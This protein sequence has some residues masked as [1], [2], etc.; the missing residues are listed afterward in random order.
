MRHSSLRHPVAVVRKIIAL[1]QPEFS[2]LAGIAESTLAKIESL[3]LPLSKQNAIR[4][5]DETG[6]S[7]RWLL[8]GNPQDP[9]PA[10]ELRFTRDGKSP[11]FDQSVFEKLRGQIE[12]GTSSNI[13]IV[14]YSSDLELKA[15]SVTA[16]RRDRQYMFNHKLRA[17]VDDLAK[18]FP[19][20]PGEMKRQER[21]IFARADLRSALAESRAAVIEMMHRHADEKIGNLFRCLA[22]YGV[23]I[24][25][26]PS[27][28]L[29][30]NKASV[31]RAKKRHTTK[32]G[33]PRKESGRSRK[34][35]RHS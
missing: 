25:D 21:E 5:A 18:E 11:Q 19:V 3:R 12:A 8:K 4:I 20:D 22:N 1:S 13:Q 33:G 17:A 9:P 16:K 24:G 29:T 32:V 6:V 35:R 23:A 27:S 26:I 30:S 14:P 10:D 15:M 7:A 28:W 34:Q 31:G 2:R